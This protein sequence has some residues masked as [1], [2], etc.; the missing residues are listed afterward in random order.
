MNCIMYYSSSG[1]AGGAT[2]AVSKLDMGQQ[3]TPRSYSVVDDWPGERNR[4]R[5]V[6]RTT[7]TKLLEGLG[8]LTHPGALLQCAARSTTRS[9][10]SSRRWSTAP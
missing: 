9:T 2:M 1:E 5:R 4:N 10:R 6:L 3:L 8:V 7:T